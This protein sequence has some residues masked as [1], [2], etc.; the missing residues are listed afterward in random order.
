MK[1]HTPKGCTCSFERELVSERK[2]S[3]D[4]LSAIFK[5]ALALVAVGVVLYLCYLFSKVMNTKMNK[6]SNT[7]NIQI[8]ERVP[9]MQDKGLVMAKIGEQYVLIG[10]SAN[11]VT[12][13]KELDAAD[14][15]FPEASSTFGK[16]A[17]LDFFNQQIKSKLDSKNSFKDK[18]K[19]NVAEGVEHSFGDSFNNGSTADRYKNDSNDEE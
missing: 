7:N 9:L 12:L 13:L 1:N 15:Q 14:L 19:G 5:L 8:L 6:V 10:Y 3:L 4:L 17:F 11:N 2:M 16:T 18:Q